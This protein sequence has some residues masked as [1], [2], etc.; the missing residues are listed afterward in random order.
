MQHFPALG[1]RRLAVA[2]TLAAVSALAAGTAAAGAAEAEDEDAATVEEVVVTAHP[3]SEDGLSEAVTVLADDDLARAVATSVGA[4]VGREP[5]IHNADY[6]AAVGRPVIH[7]MGGPR[8]RLMEDRIDVMDVSVTS[9]DHAVTVE[10]F[11]AQRVEVLKGPSTLLYGSG[12][13]G[14]VVDV[15]T[16]RIPNSVPESTDGRL[17]LMGTDNGDGL[18]GALRLDG[19]SGG[20]AWHLDAFQRR[21]KD[22]DIPGFAESDYAHAAEEMH[23]EHEEGHDDDHEVGHDDDDDHEDEH[24]DEHEEEERA[25]GTLPG[26]YSDGRGGAIGFSFVGE[27]GFAGLAVS[28]LRYEYGLPGHG[29]AHGEHGHDDEHDEHEEGEHEEEEEHHEEEEEHHEDEDEHADGNATVDLEQTRIDAEAGIM[30]PFGSFTALNARFGANDY[31]HVEVEPNGEVGTRFATESYEGRVELVQDD[32]NGWDGALGV[33]FGRRDFS[34]IGEEAFV[35]PVETSNVGFFLAGERSLAN[36]DLEAGFRLE[37]TGHAPSENV[38]TDFTA[39]SASLGIVRQLG[40]TALGVNGGYS[41]RGPSADE[42]YSDGPH[43]ATRSFEIGDPN[44]DPE[45]AWHGSVTLAWRGDRAEFDA[46]AY[47]TAFR[48]HIFQFA[49]GEEED[50]M[51]VLRYGQADASYRGLDLAAR[52]QVAAFEAGELALTAQFDTVAATLDIADN[53]NVPRLPPRRYGVGVEAAWGPATASLEYLRSSA[54]RKTAAFE[55]PTDS[56]GDLRLNLEAKVPCG[57]ADCTLFF[58]GRNLGD[59]EQ[60]NHASIVKDFAPAPGRTLEA[61]I[62]VAF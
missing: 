37:R 54:Q 21:A 60:R 11:L 40:A 46:T 7:G 39:F 19:G 33:Q 28:R 22:Y 38:D 50:E 14:G 43:L 15:Q 61:G 27:R 17:T 5:G 18:N 12:A 57:A 9:G 20:F 44:L 30:A 23:D 6:G 58:Q 29:H 3:L 59:E 24:E 8:V 31:A 52:V 25:Y 2:T 51:T 41:A 45:A 55:L 16:G 62:R 4:T 10:P 34:A 36:V 35:A 48:D 47:A 32:G 42:L 13:I 49:T 53:D 1:G 56:F 26:S